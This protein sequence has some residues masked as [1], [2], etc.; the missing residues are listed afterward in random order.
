MPKK[1]KTKE[2][3]EAKLMKGVVR[4]VKG[5]KPWKV[6]YY[7]KAVDDK[8]MLMVSKKKIPGKIVKAMKG[9]AKKKQAVMGELS[10][11]K[12]NR[13]LEFKLST[14][15]GKLKKNVKTHFGRLAMPLKKAKILGKTKGEARPPS[16]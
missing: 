7:D 16:N 15:P 9:K 2:K 8:P 11:S 5:A 4:R 13:R 10:W 12:E 14:P 3:R 1:K 6:A